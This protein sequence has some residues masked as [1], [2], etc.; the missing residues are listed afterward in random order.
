MGTVAV[1]GQSTGRGR[2]AVGGGGSTVECGPG[3]VRGAGGHPCQR[4]RYCLLPYRFREHYS[5]V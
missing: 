5:F 3:V 4:L 2:S 1:S